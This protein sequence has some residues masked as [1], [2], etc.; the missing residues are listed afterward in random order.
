VRSRRDG[1][2]EQA[3]RVGSSPANAWGIYDMLG[4]VWEWVRDC[5]DVEFYHFAPLEDPVL[6]NPDCATPEI[7]GGSFHDGGDFCRPG[8]RAAVPWST[9]QDGIGFR[10]ARVGRAR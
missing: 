2:P 7:R 5:F 10:V 8:Y 3:G 1:Q 4:N 9:G 6:W